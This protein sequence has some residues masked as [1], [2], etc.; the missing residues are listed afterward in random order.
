[1]T[2]QMRWV[3]YSLLVLNIVY[4]VSGVVGL[5]APD[6]RADRASAR[7]AS[8]PQT[9]QLLDEVQVRPSSQQ[10]APAARKRLCP[11]V[12]PWEGRTGAMEALAELEKNGYRGTVRSVE[13]EKERLN[14]V[15]LPVYADRERALKV[16][17]ELQ[18]KGVDSFIVGEGEDENAISLGYFASE[19][20]AEGLQVKMNNAGYP[21]QVRATAR[22]V[23][24]YWV[25]LRPGSLTDGGDLLRRYLSDHPDREADHAACPVPVTVP[26]NSDNAPPP[27][28][29]P[30]GTENSGE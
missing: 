16:L 25:Y 17:R 18:S 27:E 1:M 28:A 11:V 4:L 20:S 3:F 2:Q 22:T 13:V 10:A 9:L 14:W 7:T 12:G 30:A 15:Y 21:A 6:S 19:E 26:A 8:A 23:T 5:S 29:E 24:E